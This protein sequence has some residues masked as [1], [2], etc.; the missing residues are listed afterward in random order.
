MINAARWWP[1]AQPSSLPG[2]AVLLAT[3]LLASQLHE[4]TGS[5]QRALT[6]GSY[7]VVAVGSVLG[8]AMGATVVRRLFGKNTAFIRSDLAAMVLVV[9]LVAVKIAIARIFLPL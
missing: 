5:A 4:S 2:K 3:T 7:G 1:F 6:D 8:M 9:V